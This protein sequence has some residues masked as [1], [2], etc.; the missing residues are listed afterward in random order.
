MSASLTLDDL[1]KECP[2]CGGTG[3]KPEG[4]STGR[5]RSF[6]QQTSTYAVVSNPENC[7]R[8]I[9]TGRWELTDTGKAV[10]EFISIFKKLKESG[11]VP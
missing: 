9:G 1:I 8:C 4:K 7:V 11:R 2:D 10:G 3:K 6:G 5:G